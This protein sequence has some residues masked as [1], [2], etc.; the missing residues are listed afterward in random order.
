MNYLFLRSEVPDRAKLSNRIIDSPTY[1]SYCCLCS[2]TSV[3]YMSKLKD[4]A[5]CSTRSTTSPWVCAGH[6]GANNHG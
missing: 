2:W 4:V 5:L 3:A 6:C 1:A